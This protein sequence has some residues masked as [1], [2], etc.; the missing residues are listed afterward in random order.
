M[1]FF[2]TQLLAILLKF[3][4]VEIIIPLGKSYSTQ[5]EFENVWNVVSGVTTGH[6][7][8]VDEQK[9]FDQDDRKAKVIIMFSISNKVQAFI[10]DLCTTKDAWDT[11]DNVWG[12]AIESDHEFSVLAT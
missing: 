5:L 7:T 6:K 10:W 3:F 4:S 11:Q 9:K 8:N 1:L 2:S 12:E